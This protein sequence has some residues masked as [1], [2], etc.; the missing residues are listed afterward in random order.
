MPL[1]DDRKNATTTHSHD[2]S[3]SL[4]IKLL[5]QGR[6]YFY[7]RNC[8]FCQS[9]TKFEWGSFTAQND[10]KTLLM[11][12][13]SMFLHRELRRVTRFCASPFRLFSIF[14]SNITTSSSTIDSTFR[15]LRF[16]CNSDRTRQKRNLN[17]SLELLLCAAFTGKARINDK[18]KS[19]C[20]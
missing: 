18:F 16:P 6:Y 7:K 5:L 3:A 12:S 11:Q 10:K 14:S 20:I 2:K 15:F 17:F 1:T 19:W 13:E 4:S 9:K 8:F